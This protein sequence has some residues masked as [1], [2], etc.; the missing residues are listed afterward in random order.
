MFMIDVAD[1][2]GGGLFTLRAEFTPESLDQLQ[3]EHEQQP[4]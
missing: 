3:G 4:S 2:W 1:V